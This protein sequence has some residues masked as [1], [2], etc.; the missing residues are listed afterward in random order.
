MPK[1]V[2]KVPAVALRVC[3]VAEKLRKYTESFHPAAK[4]AMSLA[5][6]LDDALYGI[7]KDLS[8]ADLKAADQE[9]FEVARD[10]LQDLLNQVHEA[11]LT[12]EHIMEL[13]ADP[14]AKWPA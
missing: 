8:P 11:W 4:D 10:N 14:D 3:P 9:V 12:V 7:A 1:K 6:D 2:T 13:R 5:E